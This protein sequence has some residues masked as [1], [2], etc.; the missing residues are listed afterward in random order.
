[1]P[2]KEAVCRCS[3]GKLEE[4]CYSWERL[5]ICVCLDAALAGTVPS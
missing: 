2:V 5:R 3:S 1:M 4:P